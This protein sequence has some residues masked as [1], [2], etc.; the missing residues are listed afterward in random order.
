MS[1]SAWR[2]DGFAIA[3]T[4]IWGVN[5][6]MVKLVL[7][8]VPESRFMLIRFV[9]SAFLLV[10]YL[11]ISKEGVR[12][13]K[14]HWGHILILG[15]LG[16]GLYNILWT[17]GIHRTTAANAALLISTSPILTGLYS[18]AAGQ[19]KVHSGLW[20]GTFLAFGGVCLIISSTPGT[21]FSFDS[22]AFTG[23]FLVLCGS[24]LFSLYAVI[25]KPLL[26]HYSPVKLTTLAMIG[27][28]PVMAFYDFLQGPEVS[29]AALPPSVWLETGFII[30]AGTIAAYVLWYKGIQ[31]TTPLKTAVFHY[32]VPV[33]S[34]VLG[35][36]LLDEPVT[37]GQVL[38]AL[39]VF[40]GLMVS[41]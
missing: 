36:V 31:Q 40:L 6:P 27:G 1:P 5:Y 16:V 20:A 8:T 19:E 34:M 38:G 23:N 30:L 4:F 41:K 15:L 22:T 28:L 13:K 32:I 12:A 10:G 24:A 29:L 7:Q 3:A 26:H 21:E 17:C 9:V 14:S 25:A 37:P 11:W 18:L 33:T 39:S 2:G 35:A